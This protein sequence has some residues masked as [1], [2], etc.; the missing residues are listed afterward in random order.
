MAKKKV[1]RTKFHTKKRA[2]QREN[3]YRNGRVGEW[4]TNKTL[5][6]NPNKET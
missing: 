5:E 6:I 1:A 3:K 4:S 2:R